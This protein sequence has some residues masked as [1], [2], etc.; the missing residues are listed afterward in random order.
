[1]VMPVLS[2]QSELEGRYLTVPHF[3]DEEQSRKRM[4]NLPEDTELE[5]SRTWNLC[6]DFKSLA[7][8]LHLT[9]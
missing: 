5:G 1:M 3:V 7:F 4:S 9:L 6:L 2:I 8:S